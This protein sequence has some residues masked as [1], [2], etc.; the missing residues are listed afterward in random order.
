LTWLG[1]VVLAEQINDAMRS[2]WRSHPAP[3]PL[4]FWHRAIFGLRT[5]RPYIAVHSALKRH[6]APA[7]F[8]FLILYAGVAL[9]SHLIF[10]FEDSAG[11]ICHSSP[12]LR[13][14]EPNDTATDILFQTKDICTATG[15]NLEQGGRYLITVTPLS[16]WRDGDIDTGV[17]GFYSADQPW[18]TRTILYLGLPLKR[19]F[20][21]P[22]FRVI[23]RVGS[24]G[25]YEDFLDPDSPGSTSLQENLPSGRSGEL[26][27]YVN[28]AVLAI[29]GLQHVF[30]ANNKGTAAVSV[31]RCKDRTCQ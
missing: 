8:A 25:N 31:K 24:T 18:L 4:P 14:L 29:P 9:A 13:E 2:I 16:P 3:K 12:T 15:V 21:R 17:T 20:I 11:L 1:S 10:D 28:D 5:S 30:Y 22:W 27:L 23:A 26:F 7:L 6:I 19:T